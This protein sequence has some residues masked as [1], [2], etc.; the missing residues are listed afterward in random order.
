MKKQHLLIA[1]LWIFLTLGEHAIGQIRT[2]LPSP[3]ASVYSQVG[4]TDVT[5]DYFR[6]R[7]KDRQIFGEGDAF[8][9][10]YG[11]LWRTGANSGSKLTISEDITV[12]G[13]KVPAGEYL[14]FTMPGKD[15]WQ[16][17]L[18]SDVSIGGNT[19]GYDK[20]NE[21]VRVSVKPSKTSENVEA[22]TF[23]VEDISEDN[24]SAELAMMW[25]DTK[26]EMPF[27]VSFDEQVMAAIEAN[28]RVN[29]SNYVAAAN[30][31]LQTDRDLEQA[32]EWMDMYL[33]ANPKQ[34]WHVHTKARI[35]A[36]MGKKKEAIATA[37][38]SKE[39]AEASGNDFG[40][41]KRNEDLIDS[42]K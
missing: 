3:P 14:I 39:L 17:M 5:V 41:V 30:Y 24:T 32:L 25:A 37:K 34:F 8:L 16:V 1:S 18:Y 7:V 40:Y 12:M 42:L 29:P 22:L 15:E 20:G 27:E 9:V 38:K 33:A 26:V 21:I 28:T 31:Y 19:A 13:T 36:K 4:L 10:P 35:L 2:P 6:P 23:L 11:Q